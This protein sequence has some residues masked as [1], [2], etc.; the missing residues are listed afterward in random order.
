MCEDGFFSFPYCER[1]ECDL[2]GTTNDICDKNSAECFCKK[3]VIGPGCNMCR[4]GTFNLQKNNDDG[5]TECFC[6]G[7][8]SRCESSALISTQ[9]FDMSD[10]TL[11]IINETQLNVTVLNASLHD[12]DEFTVGADLTRI[13]L[14][15]N[16]VYFAAPS[17]YLQKRLT[18]Y[19]GNLNYNIFY[20]TGSS[21]MIYF[22]NC[23]ICKSK[24]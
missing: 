10:W 5:C 24:T 20:T 9:I 4:Q 14:T 16:L 1:C 23:S 12:V 2:A 13:N 22:F 19:G 17:T 8:T 6:F 7:K 3:N 11:V 18:T 21:G 15:D